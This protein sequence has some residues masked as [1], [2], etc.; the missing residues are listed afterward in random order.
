VDEVIKYEE[1]KN[2]KPQKIIKK[3]IITR[4]WCARCETFVKAG[5]IPDIRRI[6]LN[7]MAYILYARYRL[8]LPINKIKQSLKDIYDFNISEGEIVGQLEEA[9][10][11]FSRDYGLITELIKEAQSV[12]CDETGWRV[13]GH[14]WWI[15]VFSTDQGT[16]Y[17][18]EESRGKG[19]AQ[20]ALG[21]KKDR[22][23]ISD[24]YGVYKNLPGKKQKCWVHLL[25]D[26]KEAS[27]QMHE[28]LKEVYGELTKEIEKKKEE[29]ESKRI[30]DN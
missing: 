15:W 1:D 3:Y 23:I 30:R 18:I 8:R 25:R 9:R 24:F 22:V 2:I 10:E 12:Y 27:E 6:G 11:L 28:E 29:R 4:H 7:V 5:E 16:R 20:R 21:E 14:N 26:T 17:V 13:K 19:V